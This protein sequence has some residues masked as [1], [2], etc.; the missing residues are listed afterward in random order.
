M[1]SNIAQGGGRNRPPRDPFS[2]S[3]L[4]PSEAERLASDADPWGW[5]DQPSDEIR[6]DV[7]TQ[8]VTAVL[9]AFDAARWLPATLDGAGRLSTGRP[10]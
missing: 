7:S 9:V 1:E 8:Q 4:H 6:R 10:G 2:L 3:S 5:L